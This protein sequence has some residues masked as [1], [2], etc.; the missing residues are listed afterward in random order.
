MFNDKAVDLV[1]NHICTVFVWVEGEEVG[2]GVEGEE[3]GRGVEDVEVGGGWRMGRWGGGYSNE[4]QM[5]QKFGLTTGN[6][7]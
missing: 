1:R 3:G 7:K 4:Y 6:T 2:R 5:I